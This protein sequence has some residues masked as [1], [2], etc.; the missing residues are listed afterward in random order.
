MVAAAGNV[1]EEMLVRD[2]GS[3]A[4]RRNDLPERARETA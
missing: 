3:S 2:G 1:Q 4:S